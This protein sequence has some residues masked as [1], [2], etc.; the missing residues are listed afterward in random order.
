MALL[1]DEGLTATKT[2]AK[3][4]VGNF[5]HGILQIHYNNVK[6]RLRRML[7]SRD[8]T[9]AELDALWQRTLTCP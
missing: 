2:F 7:K 6:A 3:P 9:Q 5:V 8:K 1:G 4:V